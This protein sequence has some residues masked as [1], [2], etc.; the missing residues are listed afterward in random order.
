[1]S[2]RDKFLD[3][4][5]ALLGQPVV[6]GALDCSET[7]ALGV[8]A[9]S[10]GKLDQ[11][12]THRAQTYHDE[13]RPLLPT[14]RAI[15]GDLVFYGSL[16]MDVTKAGPSIIHVGV[17][18]KNGKVLSADGATSRITDAKVAALNPNAKVAV[19]DTPHFR[20]D[21]YVSIHRNT[22]VDSIEFVTR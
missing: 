7:V 6:W 18:L 14:E 10:D 15:P 12:Q 4:V 19:H 1:M 16:P 5:E 20:R 13:T 3:A 17:I 22:V 2:A 9:A 21:P 11:R 8:L